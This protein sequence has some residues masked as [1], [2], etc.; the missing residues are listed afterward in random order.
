LSEIFPD[1]KALSNELG[2]VRWAEGHEDR[3]V[4]AECGKLQDIATTLNG[5]FLE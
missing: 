2:F 5:N 1:L 3:R 4:G